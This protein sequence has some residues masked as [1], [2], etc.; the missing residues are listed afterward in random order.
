[1]SQKINPISNRLGIL[2]IWSVILSKYGKNFKYYNKVLYVYFNILIYINHFFKNSKVFID[3]VNIQFL[4]KITL[5]NIITFFPNNYNCFLKS[6][7]LAKVV[8]YWLNIPVI[9][10]FY[11][12]DSITNSSFLLVNYTIFLI[13]QGA[14]IKVLFQNIYKILKDQSSNFKLIYTVYGIKKIQLRGF[15]IKL[16]G[17]FEMSRSQMSKTVKCNFGSLPLT[18][19]NGYIEYSHNT[20][21][22]KFGSCGLK[23]WLFY[24]F[25]S[26]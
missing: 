26:F 1:M 5:I 25:K 23:I 9:I 11:K 6:I 7:D 22:T 8:S 2:Q 15:K 20:L 12:K 19:L 17:C 13:L 4:Q 10:N 3:N 18:K 16:S 24:E 21:Y 14:P